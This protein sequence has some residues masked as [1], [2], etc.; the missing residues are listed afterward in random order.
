MKKI[1][2]V[3]IMTL[4]N[5]KGEFGT[6]EW[7]EQ[8]PYIILTVIV[9]V[10]IFL[11]VNYYVNITVNVKSLQVEVLF[12]R[13]MY[14]PNSIVYTDLATGVLYPGVIDM[15]KFTDETLDN[16]IKYSSER[17]ISAKLELYNQNGELKKTAYLNNIWFNR[18][19]PL[20][21]AGVGGASSAKIYTKKIPL[22]YRENEVNT[23][24]FLKV[25]IL[26]PN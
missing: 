24:G 5:K 2:R 21:R 3:S 13:L 4:K 11:L 12:N 8:I 18:L 25:E 7:L 20:A 16:S 9:F 17:H 22:S 14:S 6:E 19:E 10:G 15:E 1:K 26:L 23:P